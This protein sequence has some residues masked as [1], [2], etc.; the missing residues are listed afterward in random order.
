LLRAYRAIGQFRGQSAAELSAWL[1]RIL[2]SVL[3]NAVRDFSRERRDVSMERSLEAAIDDS[4]LRLENWLAAAQISPRELAE[5][6]EQLL[7]LAGALTKLP[8]DQ[9]DALLLRYYQ[10]LPLQEIGA[11]MGRTRPAV[12]SLL[13][14]GLAQLRKLFSDQARS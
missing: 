6:N 1:R 10:G 7:W 5:R 4:S 2:A 8:G 9:R 14:R 13:R 12:A 11:R 3:A